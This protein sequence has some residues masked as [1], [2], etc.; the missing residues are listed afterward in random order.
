MIK[1]GR[2]LCCPV[3]RKLFFSMLLMSVTQAVNDHPP[4]KLF[5]FLPTRLIVC[6]VMC[7]PHALFINL[8]IIVRKG[9]LDQGGILDVQI[10]IAHPVEVRVLIDIVLVLDFDGPGELLQDFILRVLNDFDVLVAKQ[11][12][13]LIGLGRF[14]MLDDVN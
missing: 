8:D 3:S 10:V 2:Y 6:E 5:E 13:L 4:I 12:G 1:S 9:L 7:P 11:F 14:L